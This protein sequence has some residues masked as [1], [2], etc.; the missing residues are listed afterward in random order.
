MSIEASPL[1]RLLEIW[2]SERTIASNIVTWHTDPARP[3]LYA[4]FPPSLH[5]MLVK[6]LASRHIHQLYTHQLESWQKTEAGQNVVVVTGTASG[7]TLCYNLPVLNDALQNEDSTALYL[8]P[9]KALTQDQKEGLTALVDDLSRTAN[10]EGQPALRIP[11]AIYDGDTPTSQRSGIRENA[12]LLMTN[13][14]MLHMGILPHHTLWNRFLRNLRFVIIDEVH[15]YRGVF[16]SHIANLI[17]RLRRV[18]QFYSAYPQFILTSATIA[19]PVELSERLIEMPVEMVSTD[20]SPRGRRHF[21]LYNPP[22]I[23]QQL[24][25]R[26]SAQAESAHLA[27]DLLAYGVQTL[28][29]ARARR[30][31]ELLLRNLQQKTSPDNEIH[32]YRSGYL[33]QERRSIERS[34]R[35][36]HTRAVVTTNA[37]ELGIDIGSAGA[38]ILVGYPGTIAATRQQSGRAGRRTES[39]L[40][41]LVA[42]GGPLDQYLMRHPEY[43]FDRSPERALI[44]PDNLLILLQH[45]RCAAFEL[46]FRMGDRFGSVTPDLIKDLLAYLVQEGLLHISGERF[47]WM[48]DQYPANHVSLRS[49]SGNTIILQAEEEGAFTTV[50]EVDDVS[51]TWMVHPQ[52][53]YIHEGKTYQVNDLSL[54]EN[55]AHL[56]AVDVD[57]Y[58]EA[59]K[60]ISIIELEKLGSNDAPGGEKTYGEIQVTS[61]VVGYRRI[62]WYTHEVLMENPLDMPPTQLRT[63]GYWFSLSDESVDR[64]RELGAWKNDPNNYGPNW[65]RQRDLARQRD[66]FRCQSCGALETRQSHHVHHKVPFRNF[67]SFVMANHLENLITL[68]PSCHKKAELVVR[69]RS[70]LGGLSYALHNI[71][72]LFLMCDLGDL[73]VHYEP[74]SPL[75]NGKP[76]VVLFDLL[77]AGIGLSETLYQVHDDLMQRCYDLVETCEC[78]DGCP[79]CVGPAGENGISGKLE[80]LTLLAVLAGKIPLSG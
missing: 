21:I 37:L 79:G 38:V 14:D 39:A 76:A 78:L 45:L 23:Q 73:G 15:I 7:K 4:S 19:N 75:A 20:G 25:I 2:R 64:L 40:A 47:F 5:P 50:G 12:R 65:L 6:A 51:A 29:F 43:I 67:T 17:R 72:P 26:R 18:A 80:T 55:K 8:F 49:A 54:E 30:S 66:G 1:E 22:V 28:L 10:G 58:T 41:V 13:P 68:C 60:E 16:G 74:E 34:L 61:Q 32:G 71:A 70:G 42:S 11:A 52:A 59:Q 56:K 31:V 44:N 53:I 27:D 35:Q 77:P 9:T 3:A 24:G 62:R 33:A 46:P 48:A 36:G 57:F 69:M 63:V